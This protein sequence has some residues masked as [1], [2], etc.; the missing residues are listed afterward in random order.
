MI[1]ILIVRFNNALCAIADMLFPTTIVVNMIFFVTTFN[2]ILC[3]KYNAA[4][5]LLKKEL[6]LHNVGMFSV[7]FISIILGYD[8]CAKLKFMV[9]KNKCS[10]YYTGVK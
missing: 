4:I 6:A 2:N 7:F 10:C 9:F 1:Y 3:I 5:V 8:F